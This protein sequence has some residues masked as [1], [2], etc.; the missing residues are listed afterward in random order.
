I[1]SNEK[2]GNALKW[3][4]KILERAKIPYEITG[5][6]AACV[7]GS[8]RSINDI[9]IDIPED[10]F[11]DILPDVKD[12]IAYG[13]AQF[14]DEKWD[15]KLMTLNYKGQEIDIGGAY[16]TKI[17]DDTS[18]IWKKCL[19]NLSTVRT[20]NYEDIEMPVVDP[21]DLIEYKKFLVDPKF[22]QQEND[23]E[24]VSRYIGKESLSCFYARLKELISRNKFDLI[25]GAGDSGQVMAWIT[26]EIFKALDTEIPQIVVLPIY[27]HAD[28]AETI[29]FNNNIFTKELRSKTDLSKVKQILFVDDEVGNGTVVSAVAGLIQNGADDN[30]ERTITILSENRGYNPPIKIAGNTVYFVPSRNVEANIYNAIQYVVPKILRMKTKD[31]LKDLVEYPSEKL[32]LNVLLGLSIKKFNDCDPIFSDQYYIIMKDRIEDFEPTRIAF[33]AELKSSIYALKEKRR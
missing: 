23:I 16:E 19:T 2:I 29:L 5:G 18:K 33:E 28:E 7:Y 8:Q 3:I 1:D 27:R 14:K 30:E 11:D 9:D 15:L 12:Y 25:I 20:M 32:A 31:A 6:F 10:R 22:P 4:A 24:S 26:R 21:G 17:Y 13:P